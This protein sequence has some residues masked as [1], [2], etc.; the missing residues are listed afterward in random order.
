MRICASV[1]EVT[2]SGADRSTNRAGPARHVAD[3]AE[4]PLRH[5]VRH[6]SVAAGTTT[7]DVIVMAHE[8]PE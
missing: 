2:R 6:S 5:A 3:I 4:D 7:L 8:A 1:P